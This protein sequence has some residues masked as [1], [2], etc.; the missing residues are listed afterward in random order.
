MEVNAIKYNN[1]I[2]YEV[3]VGI[4]VITIQNP[5]VNALNR[6][7]L[8][9]LDECLDA[10]AADINVRTVIL[11][12]EGKCFIAGADIK[13][14]AGM[15]FN[16][17]VTGTRSGQKIISRLEQIP[18]PVI[19]AINGAALGGGLETTL[20]CDIR[21]ASEKALLGLPE[22]TLGILP[23]Y[24]GVSRLSNIIGEGNAKMFIFT[25]QPL[26]ARQALTMGIVQEVVPPE[27]LMG[28]CMEVASRIAAAAPLP[29]KR[30]KEGIRK[31]RDCNM[32]ASLE[33]EVLYSMECFHSED[34]TE[35]IDAFLNKRKPLFKNK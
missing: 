22:V 32:E 30:V 3:N 24:G 20:A 15:D 23:A 12:G 1:V 2:N 16:E 18:V 35:G 8:T 13:E 25:G 5:P 10:V 26:D 21:I 4:A 28:R 19:A 7:V 6:A 34:R 11:T 27:R 14:F 9:G 33:N 31:R 17:L 29:V